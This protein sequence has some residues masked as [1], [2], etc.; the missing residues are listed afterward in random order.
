MAS[1]CKHNYWF[2]YVKILNL[3]LD[4]C[5]GAVASQEVPSGHFLDFQRQET[6]ALPRQ[7]SREVLKVG[8]LDDQYVSGK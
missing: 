7:Y 5:K 1:R 8:S 2:L 4:K 6:V 3:V